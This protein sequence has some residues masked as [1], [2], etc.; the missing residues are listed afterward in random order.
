MNKGFEV[1]EAHHLFG[2]DYSKI[3]VLVHPQSVIHALV[4][5]VDGS[6]I[7]QMASPDMRMP[8]QYALLETERLQN[9]FGLINLA[10][11][12]HLTFSSPGQGKIPMHRIRIRGRQKRRHFD[13]GTKFRE[14]RSR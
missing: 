1:I 2:L 14:Q 4:E 11:V 6:V 5:F 10:K 7:A 3:D 12:G 13:S 9:K 8:I